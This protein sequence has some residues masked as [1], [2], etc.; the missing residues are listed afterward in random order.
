MP[1]FGY[2]P[3][4][5]RFLIPGS[6]PS[7]S[8]AELFAVIGDADYSQCSAETF[9]VE[10]NRDPVELQDRLGG[11]VKTGTVVGEIARYNI[12]AA[13]AALL[14]HIQAAA[15]GSEGKIS[16]GISVY[17]LGNKGMA[18]QLA[19]DRQR[20]GLE[21][22]KALKE[23]GR[24]VRY[25]D[26]K[27]RDLSAVIVREND[28][29]ETGGDWALMASTD[30]VY[31][32]KTAATQDYK[33]W[34]RRD[35]GRPAADAVSGMLPPK[36]A[37]LMVNLA[38]VEPTDASILDPF[39]GSGTVL[40][41]ASVIGFGRL[42]GQDI[43][44]KAVDD[45][46]ENM[47]WIGAEAD[48]VQGDAQTIHTRIKEPVDAV[49]T[50]PYLGPPR[51]QKLT[52]ED[53]T[54]AM[55]DLT[56]LYDASFTS[57]YKVLKPGGRVVVSFP[58]FDTETARVFIPMKAVLEKIGFSIVP[59]VPESAPTILKERTPN[60]GLVYRRPDAIVSRDIVILKK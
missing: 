8:L 1:D 23:L 11:F 56:K 22:K 35:F 3:S 19:K 52:Q 36:I 43:E 32:G 38:G 5:M 31:I 6:H 39:C 53:I 58:V 30:R 17:E 7:L 44:R 46:K 37:R 48:I 33:E 13:V 15:A 47:E 49:V 24:P 59:I 16:F 34:G 12:Q 9:L 14:P 57:I 28:I 42:L 25:V 10:T 40:M 2:T 60:G 20:I 4:V 51:K 55:R 54:K 41:E 18:A 45:T 21:L 50:E 26:S 27:E 29:L